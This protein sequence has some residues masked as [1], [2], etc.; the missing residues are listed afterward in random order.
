MEFGDT[1]HNLRTRAGKSRYRL[2]QLT[3]LDQ[4]YLGRLE[5]GEKK[6]SPNT[7]MMLGLALVHGCT[8]I[9]CDDIDDLLLA[10]RELPQGHANR[11][12]GLPLL[13]HC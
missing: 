8:E 2:W 7:V 13:H 10:G 9:T 1:L 4:S 12:P 11:L 6:P 5:K 3:G